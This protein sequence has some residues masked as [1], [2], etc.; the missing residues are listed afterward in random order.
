MEAND[1]INVKSYLLFTIE[2][3]K[4]GAGVHNV[5]NI[6]EIQPITKIPKA[7]AYMKGIINLRG[8][9]LPVIDTR[10]K[11][12]MTPT[13]FTDNTCIVVMDFKLDD[14]IIHLGAL[15]DSV[16]SVYEINENEIERTPNIGNG[17]RTEF[18]TGVAKVNEHF[19]MILD[20]VKLFTSDEISCL[21]KSNDKQI[22][23]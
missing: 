21:K 16:D 3:E 20:L 11:L 7:P 14:E 13:E 22:T 5:L 23:N 18:I 8:V 2:N 15:V 6:L 17:Y 9:V 4:Y 19:V 12:D 1:N 10:I